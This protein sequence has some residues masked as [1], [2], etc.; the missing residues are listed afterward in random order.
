MTNYSKHILFLL[1]LFLSTVAFAQT[2]SVGIGYQALISKPDSKAYP[3]IAV[4]SSPLTNT[5][6]CLRFTFLDDTRLI[7]YQETK[8]IKTDEFGMVNTFIGTGEQTDGYAPDFDAIDW[9]TTDKVLVVELDISGLC[10]TFEEISNQA[11]SSTPF[12]YNALLAANVSGVVEISNGGTGA[13]T[14]GGAR[15]NLGIANVDNTSDLNKPISIATQASLDGKLDKVLKNPEIIVTSPTKT[16]AIKG[17]EVSSSAQN[18]VVTIDPVTGILSRSSFLSTVE[19]N[20]VDY[21]AVEGQLLFATPSPI[22]TINKVNVYRNGIR[23]N[24]S[25]AGDS[26]IKLEAAASCYFNDEIKII[27]FN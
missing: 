18:Q 6:I 26:T 24:A 7:E 27:Q 12:A 8:N 22:T 14:L 5:D 3:G 2:K 10:N 4:N 1:L 16:L 21:R 23:I 11:F 20:V 19:E 13:D 15:E 9:K 25:V 17:L